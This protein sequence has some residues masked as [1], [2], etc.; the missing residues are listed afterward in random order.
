[1]STRP[2]TDLPSDP[3]RLAVLQ[4]EATP[5]DVRNNSVRA[6]TLVREAARRGA[7]VAVLPE[8]HLCGY[9]LPTLASDP[10]AC[11]VIADDAGTVTDGRLDALAEQAEATG[12][13]VLAG[14]AV[15]RA[16][17]RL[18]NSIL[19][20]DPSGTVRLG[21]D[22][23]HLWHSDEAEIFAAGLG[24]DGLWEV[25]GWRLGGAICYDM[26]FAAHAGAS[27]LSGVHA[28]VCASAFVVG[29]EKRAAVYMPARALEN[30]IYSVFANAYG[31]PVDRRTGGASAIYGPDGSL[32]DIATAD[33][34][35]VL[36]G[37]LEPQRI[38]STRSFL[39]MLEERSR[40]TVEP[41]VGLEDQDLCP[42]G[43]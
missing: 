4:A 20:F 36:V 2:L 26:S 33:G 24:G 8:L 1:M 35:Q 6:A 34:E 38:A 29:A 15:R 17:G 40:T 11:E 32:V 25:D 22:K 41:E 39:R 23:Q 10:S 21:Y 19:G 3:L 16:D 43:V 37:E 5:A 12:T 13:L 14:A 31:G 27:A 9:D 7:R 18:V 42:M 28:Y 30:T